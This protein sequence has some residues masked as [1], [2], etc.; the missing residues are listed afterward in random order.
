MRLTRSEI[1]ANALR[2]AREWQG[3]TD[4]QAEAQSFWTELFAVFGVH[5]RSVASFERKVKNVRGNRSRMDVFYT[6]MMIGEHKSRGENLDAAASQ[7]FGYVQVLTRDG[8]RGKQSMPDFDVLSCCKCYR[9]D[10][11]A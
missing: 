8:L 7:A 2:F 10:G 4:E 11:V 5:R 3:A 6:G 1:R 9:G